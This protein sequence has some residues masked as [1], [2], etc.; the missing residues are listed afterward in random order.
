[1]GC[2]SHIGL[3]PKGC[4][5]TSETSCTDWQVTRLCWPSL[6][7]Q[8]LQRT[9]T[10]LDPSASSYFELLHCIFSWPLSGLYGYCCHCY[11]YCSQSEPWP[12]WPYPSAPLPLPAFSS[13]VPDC[14]DQD[15]CL[16]QSLY[17]LRR[18]RNQFFTQVPF[19]TSAPSSFLSLFWSGSLKRKHVAST[20]TANIFFAASG[21]L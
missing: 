2:T 19:E 17:S 6:A 8:C 18:N 10:N 15:C 4:L 13:E 21:L 7:R 3:S 1:M 12:Q 14:Q 9:L 20:P 16:G 5:H 11:S